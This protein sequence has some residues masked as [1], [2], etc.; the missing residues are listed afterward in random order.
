MKKKDSKLTQFSLLFSIPETLYFSI[1]Q[2]CQLK[3][4]IGK[5]LLESR[6]IKKLLRKSI[7]LGQQTQRKYLKFLMGDFM[8]SSVK[9]N[10]KRMYI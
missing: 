6:R 2:Y 1:W 7:K 8:V 5:F 10:I 9:I 4:F 3:M